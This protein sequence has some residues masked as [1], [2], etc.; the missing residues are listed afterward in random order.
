MMLQNTVTY[1]GSARAHRLGSWFIVC[2]RLAASFLVALENRRNQMALKRVVS[3]L[4][5]HQLR[6]IGYDDSIIQIN[7]LGQC[8]DKDSAGERVF[9]YR[10]GGLAGSV[11]HY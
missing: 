11:W 1:M 8:L 9:S 2:E 7:C 6:D 3:R 10:A 5:P 4:S